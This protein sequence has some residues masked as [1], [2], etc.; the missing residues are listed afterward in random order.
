MVKVL[1]PWPEGP[2]DPIVKEWM[3]AHGVHENDI[4]EY[5]IR[6]EAGGPTYLTLTTILV[7]ND[8]DTKEQK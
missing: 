7:K 1:H 4:T 8:S 5:T 6:R 2:A 3:D